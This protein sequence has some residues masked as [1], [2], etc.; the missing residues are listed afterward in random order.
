MKRILKLYIQ[1]LLPWLSVT[2]YL[3]LLELQAAFGTDPEPLLDRL[4]D[5]SAILWTLMLWIA[6]LSVGA[7]FVSVPFRIST[8][9]KANHLACNAALILVTAFHFF[10]WL[11]KWKLP[12]RSIVIIAIALLIL[13]ALLSLWAAKRRKGRSDTNSNSV[14]PRLNDCFYFAAFPVIVASFLA[15]VVKITN[16]LTARG[17]VAHASLSASAETKP[18]PNVVLMIYDGLRAQNMSVYGHLRETTPHLEKFA[19]HSNLYMQMHANSTTTQP[20]MTTILS[21]RHPFSHGRLTREVPLYGDSQNI[22]RVLRDNGYATVAVTSNRE[23][24]LY[25]LG[26]ARYL[27]RREHT[28]F[29]NLTLSWLRDW[30]VF[31]TAMGSRIYENLSMIF[32]FLG[33]PRRTSTYGYSVDTLDT[34]KKLLAELRPPFFL[35]VHLHEPHDPYYAS[36]AFAGLFSHPANFPTTRRMTLPFYGNYPPELETT[37]AHY[38]DQYDESIRFLDSEF[39][40]FMNFLDK[41]PWA[42][43][44]LIALTSDHGESFERGYLNHGEELYENSTRVPLIIRF[45]NQQYAR[46]I[47]GLVQSTDIAPTILRTIGVAIPPWMEGQPLTEGSD[48]N[49]TETI[50]VNFKHPVKG[51][52]YPLPT[53][54]AIWSGQYKMIVSCDKGKVELYDLTEDPGELVDLSSHLGTIVQLLKQRLALRLS[55]QSHRPLMSCA[56]D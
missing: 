33:F 44:L 12:N 34:A 10:R 14:W 5:S 55:V 6:G 42:D 38:R 1:I 46:R 20:S 39:G 30:G 41:S 23:A 3:W 29:S 2:V 25:S 54:L 35:L 13:C 11:G 51:T 37:V 28:T 4:A 36:A 47:I 48:P 15:V 56:Y 9:S 18:K 49:N 27:S 21:G 8:V 40:K 7:L 43:N 22:I 17:S 26:F 24:S 19:E 50:A 52:H 32:P 16:E 45:P 31:P 53:K